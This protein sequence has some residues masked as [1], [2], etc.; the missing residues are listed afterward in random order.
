MKTRYQLLKLTGSLGACPQERKKNKEQNHPNCYLNCCKLPKTFVCLQGIKFSLLTGSFSLI[1]RIF[2]CLKWRIRATVQN[3][4]QFLYVTKLCPLKCSRPKMT[5][6]DVI[7]ERCKP[8]SQQQCTNDEEMGRPHGKSAEF[9]IYFP[10][11]FDLEIII[12]SIM[13]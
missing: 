12:R 10:A 1:I 8:I 11:R 13:Q 7:K 3:A 4:I 9:H 2:H 5:V 6:I